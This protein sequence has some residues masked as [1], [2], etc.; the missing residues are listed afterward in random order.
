MAWRHRDREWPRQ[1]E[2]KRAR[3]EE[4]IRHHFLLL[5]GAVQSEILGDDLGVL[6]QHVA[7]GLQ[8]GM[9]RPGRG[10]SRASEPGEPEAAKEG[11]AREKE[12]NETVK[13]RFGL[14]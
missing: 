2:G 9:A 5:L 14:K 8:A 4:G 1:S 12:R 11:K 13:S 7:D 6:Q 10:R 3:Q